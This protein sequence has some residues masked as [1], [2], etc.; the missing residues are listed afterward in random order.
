MPLDK[1]DSSRQVEVFHDLAAPSVESSGGSENKKLIISIHIPKTGGTTFLEFLKAGVQEVLYLDWGPGSKDNRLYR[2]RK[3]LAAQFESITDLESL[4]GRSVIHGH[5]KAGKYLPKFPKAIYVTWLRDPVERVASHYFFWQ[6]RPF[7]DDALCNKVITEKMTLEEFARLEAIRNVQHRFLSP[8]G[9]EGFAF[10]GITEEY[11][12]S[13]EL[14]RRLIYPDIQFDPMMRNYNPDR[15]RKFYDLELGV[16]ER[17]LK[18]NDLDAYTYLDG[19]HRF[20]RMCDQV[21]L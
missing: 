20:R 3:R 5:F 12:R 1:D 14:F 8:L 4:S 17:I 7:M 9:V 15:P 11:E 10:I 6:R 16:R 18:L 2:H 19:I 21:G 13:L